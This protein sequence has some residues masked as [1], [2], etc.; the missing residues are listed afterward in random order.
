MKK[1]KERLNKTLI[2][3]GYKILKIQL[4]LVHTL[5]KTILNSFWNFFIMELNQFWSQWKLLQIQR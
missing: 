3:L 1:S 4:Y 2:F 5:S